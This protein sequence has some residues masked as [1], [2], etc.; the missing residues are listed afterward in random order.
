MTEKYRELSASFEKLGIEVANHVKAKNDVKLAIDNDSFSKIKYVL[1]N[2]HADLE[3]EDNKT[4][5]KLNKAIEQTYISD[6]DL[7][8]FVN[9]QLETNYDDAINSKCG[10]NH[11]YIAKCVFY[12]S[13]RALISDRIESRK[14]ADVIGC[15]NSFIDDFPDEDVEEDTGEEFTNPFEEEI[16]EEEL[17]DGTPIYIQHTL[18]SNEDEADD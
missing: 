18:F 13:I 3:C 10:I 8:E 11:M 14:D 7:L 2:L 4:F 9:E 15:I 5:D 17:D 6:E 12:N 16:L 1:E